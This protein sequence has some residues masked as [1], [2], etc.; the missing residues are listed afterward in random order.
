MVENVPQ[1]FSFSSI[2][3]MYVYI[4]KAC[5]AWGWWL[6]DHDHD[7]CLVQTWWI[8]VAQ[9]RTKIL[10]HHLGD[11]SAEIMYERQGGVGMYKWVASFWR[12]KQANRD[13]NKGVVIKRKESANH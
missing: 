2:D 4:A 9:E 11:V 6:V 12:T 3:L 13:G 7:R 1:A 10:V 5:S 8:G